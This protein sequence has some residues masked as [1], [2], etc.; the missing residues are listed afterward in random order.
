MTLRPTVLVVDDAPD[1][2][3]LV[4]EI[5]RRGG[6]DVDTASSGNDAIERLTTGWR[7]AV[8]L[9]DVQMPDQDGWDTIAAMRLLPDGDR[10]PVVLCTV[11]EQPDDVERAAVLGCVGYVAK[12]FAIDDLQRAVAGAIVGAP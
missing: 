6:F 12:P 2:R 1:V 5:L 8:V 4:A 10:I 11:K 3:F 9:L 7:P